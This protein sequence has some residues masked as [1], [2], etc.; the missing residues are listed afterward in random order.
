L[1][2]Q[3]RLC[4]NLSQAKSQLKPVKGPGLAC[5]FDG[6][7]GL[8]FGFGPEPLHHY[9]SFVCIHSIPDAVPEIT[10]NMSF[11]TLSR[12]SGTNFL[13][14]YHQGLMSHLLLH[15]FFFWGLE[16]VKHREKK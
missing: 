9:E 5:L 12:H 7:L 14:M 15:L 1:S 8:A 16:K 11:N 3:L 4:E 2:P 10:M 13:G 6:W